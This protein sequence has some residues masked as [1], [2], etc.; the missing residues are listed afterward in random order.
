MAH[1]ARILW[2]SSPRV[3]VDVS[4]NALVCLVLLGA[5]MNIALRIWTYQVWYLRSLT[6]RWPQRAEGT[7]VTPLACNLLGFMKKADSL[8]FE[9]LEHP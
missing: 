8:K 2:L 7:L 4:V 3:S 1:V 9:I 5:L 6:G